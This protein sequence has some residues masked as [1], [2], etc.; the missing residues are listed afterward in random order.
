MG[1]CIR[2][3]KQVREFEEDIEIEEEKDYHG[4]QEEESGKK[5]KLVLT[6]EELEWL[7][8]E[9]KSNQGKRLED[10]LQEIERARER[11]KTKLRVWKPSLESI[12]EYPEGF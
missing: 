12:T 1:N 11:G 7:M 2:G 8:F 6:K 5:I 4:H 3:G 9:L 10:V